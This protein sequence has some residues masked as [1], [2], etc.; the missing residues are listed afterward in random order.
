[1]HVVVR[2]KSIAT[3]SDGTADRTS[4]SNP[5]CRRD[6]IL[7]VEAVLECDEGRYR[8]SCGC[9]SGRGLQPINGRI[10]GPGHNRHD[11]AH[12]RSTRPEMLAWVFGTPRS[13]G[14]PVA[15]LFDPIGTAQI[16]LTDE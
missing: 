8:F 6:F 4:T 13:G 2:S 10:E 3:S 1:M 14:D 7:S 12:R 16:D 9:S 11:V 5:E 15:D